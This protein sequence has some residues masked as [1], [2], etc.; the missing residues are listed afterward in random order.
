MTFSNRSLEESWAARIA[1][2]NYRNLQLQ[3]FAE[4]P[5]GRIVPYPDDRIRFHLC[6]RT[7]EALANCHSCVSYRNQF[8]ISDQPEISFRQPLQRGL[9]RK[10]CLELR[11]EAGKRS[12]ER[13]GYALRQQEFRC[14]NCFIMS[15]IIKDDRILSP[16]A[17]AS[18]HED[19]MRR[20][21]P[22]IVHAGG[23]VSRS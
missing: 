1:H 15:D 17:V 22:R 16:V 5:I 6:F 21:Y 10:A 11:R 23:D 18:I 20:D 3:L 9:T 7:T 8:R 4:F 2:R 12:G 14:R 13:Y 19:I